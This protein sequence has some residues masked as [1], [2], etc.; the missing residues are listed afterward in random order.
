MK[1]TRVLLLD[2]S[3]IT[4]PFT[5]IVVERLEVEFDL[6][7]FDSNASV[8][9]QFRGVD[10][11]VD[12]GGG[13][14]VPEML[15]AGADIRLWQIFGNGIDHFDLDLWSS[16]GA[17]VANCPGPGHAV[18]LAEHAIMGLLMLL[19]RYPE[20]RQNLVSGLLY[21]PLGREMAGLRLL[22]IGFGATAREL[23]IRASALGIK[24]TGLDVLPVGSA[25]AKQW[26][27]E[28]VVTPDR[29]DEELGLHDIVSLHL[30]LNRGT[31][32][33]LNAHRLALIPQGSLVVNVSRGA[34]V[35]QVALRVALNSGHLSGAV[36]DVFDPEPLHSSDELMWLPNVIATPHVAGV[37]VETA[38]RR[39]DTTIDN[40]RRVMAGEDPLH[41]VS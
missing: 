15:D 5:P 24:V 35:D 16:R 29:L 22:T 25:Q 14:S 38:N 41:R 37:T 31:H 9:P 33:I 17:V 11:V 26:G 8:K 34:L 3:R 19:K 1:R 4:N 20:A 6:Q 2:G 13:N 18:A 27:A 36:L 12:I 21:L 23:A 10:V 39:A 32:H 7:E 40:I 28:S 30:P